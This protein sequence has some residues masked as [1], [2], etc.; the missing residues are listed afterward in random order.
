[1]IAHF[2]LDAFFVAVECINDPSLKGKPIIVGGSRE[3]GVVTAASYETRKFGVHS[4]MPMSKAMQ[5]C[6]QAIVV[7]GSRGEYS[8]YSRWVTNIIAQKAP[9]FEKASIDEFYIDLSG[10]EKYHKPYEWTIA[11]REDIILE[12]GLNISFG[13]GANKM[14]AKI[15]TDEAKPNGYLIIPPGNEEA[16]LAPLRVNKI[17]GVGEQTYR[18]LLEMGIEYIRDI[19]AVS[20]AVL[21][22]RLGRYGL[23]LLQ[24]AKGIH[25]GEVIQ[26]HEAKSVSTENTFEE[27]T[28][29]MDFLMSE[30][31]RMTEKVAFELREDNK[32]AGVIAV[33]IRY[34]DFETTSR[35]TTIPY[36]FY[37]DELIPVAKELFHKLYRKGEKV[38]LMGVRLS[39]LTSEAIQT[40]LFSN[41]EKKAELYKA[42]DSLKNKFGKGSV[43]KGGGMK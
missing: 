39:E 34:P 37:D 32:T 12:T 25:H 6:P 30:L 2:D 28:N 24:K 43:R 7:K 17:P 15:A 9:L 16:F 31:V 35:Q 4:A 10:M 33:K 29:D 13:L 23:E 14:I 26:Y 1:M 18:T 3:R 8:K 5:L 11:L 22:N 20:P 42:I 36:T 21:E 19:A 38:R 27:N 40:N 41:K